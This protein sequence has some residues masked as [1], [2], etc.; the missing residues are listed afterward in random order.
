MTQSSKFRIEALSMS[1]ATIA[2]LA[3]FAQPGSA[4]TV[5]SLSQCSGPSR[6]N[7]VDCCSKFVYKHPQFWMI[8]HDISCYKAVKCSGSRKSLNA[9]APVRKCSVMRPIYDMDFERKG[10]KISDIRLKTEI[11]RIGTTVLGLPLYR[12]QYRNRVGVYLGVMAQD[13]LKVEP[14]AVSMDADGYFMVDYGKLGISMER[15]Q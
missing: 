6:Q 12:F 1:F 8:R 9:V 13:V 2:T 14:S 4:Q 5:T 10:K 11:H 15:I 7:V 3:F